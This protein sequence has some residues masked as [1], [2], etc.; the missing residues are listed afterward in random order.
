MSI[1]TNT[2]IKDRNGTTKSSYLPGEKIK[3]TI[4]TTNSDN[5]PV[6]TRLSV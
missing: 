6:K 2:T 1:K 5:Q 4:Q 3:L